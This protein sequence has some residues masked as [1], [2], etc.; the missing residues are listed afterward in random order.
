MMQAAFAGFKSGVGPAVGCGDVD[1]SIREA[2]WE[3]CAQSLSQR[4]YVTP[5]AGCEERAEHF[6]VGREIDKKGLSRLPIRRCLQHSGATEA[7][8]SDEE[9]FAELRLAGLNNRFG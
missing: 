8:V 4:G 2:L 6:N 1:E 9:F 7:T 5:R 3:H